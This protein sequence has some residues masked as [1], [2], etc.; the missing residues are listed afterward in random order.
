MLSKKKINK[1]SLNGI[2]LDFGQTKISIGIITNSKVIKTEKFDCNFSKNPKGYINQIEDIIQNH[3]SNKNKIGIA[4]SGRVDNNGNW[5]AVNKK[6]LGDIKVP[7]KKIIEK[8]FNTSVN[9]MND[10]NAACLGEATFGSVNK[11]N[12]VGYVTVS[13]GIGVGI[14]INRK[15]LISDS[16]LA[17]HLGF[18]T[19]RKGIGKCGSGRLGTFESISSGKSIEK[20][21]IILGY[22]YNAKQVYEAN[23]SG[24]KWA[25]KIINQSAEAIAELCANMKAIFDL[26]VVVIGGSIGMAKGYTD[27]VK[28]YLKKEP[29]LFQVK[30][31]KSSLGIK[32]SKFGILI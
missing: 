2:A 10:A 25:S 31:V 24:K 21:S 14:V 8:K 28:K 3:Y 4:I 29:K 20:K 12:R 27:L 32:A 13:T 18:T 17:S 6:N 22:E 11:Y 23:L 16:G 26:D 15:N 7:L 19:S 1:N 9:I 30:I 5:Y